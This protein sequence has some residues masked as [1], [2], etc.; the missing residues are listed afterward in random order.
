MISWKETCKPKIYGGL[1]IPSIEALYFACGCTVVWRFYNSKSFLFSWWKEKYG[2]FWNAKITKSSFYWKALCDV[3]KSLQHSLNF[4]IIPN[5]NLS[6]FWDPW[7]FGLTVADRLEQANLY[8]TISPSITNS[9]VNWF[10]STDSWNS[11]LP[12]PSNLDVLIRSIPI[13]N[14]TVECCWTKPYKPSFKAFIMQ[15]FEGAEK[16]SWYNFVWHKHYAIRFSIFT[17]IAF[18]N[19]L[20]TAQALAAR[21]IP[22]VT[23]CAFC[24]TQNETQNHLFFECDFTFNILKCLLPRMSSMLLRPNLWQVFCEI[25]ERETDKILTSY[26][27]LTMSAMVYFLW[28]ARNDRLFGNTNESTETIIFKIKRAVGFKTSRTKCFQQLQNMLT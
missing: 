18:K 2:S 16:V 27:Y 12:V 4:K 28:K 10:I 3:A 25:G 24:K 15:F 21:G 11:A 22:V 6:F 7:C 5:S 14:D 19:G 9:K 17:W 26:M 1:G 20:K 23:L 13:T 8:S